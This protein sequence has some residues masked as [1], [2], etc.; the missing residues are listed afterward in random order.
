[1][2][3]RFGST[4]VSFL[5][6]PKRELTALT[7]SSLLERGRGEMGLSM[8]GVIPGDSEYWSL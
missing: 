1:M 7:L 4:R 6:V 2:G 8:Y 5:A 3:S